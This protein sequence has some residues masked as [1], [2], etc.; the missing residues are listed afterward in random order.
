MLSIEERKKIRNLWNVVEES[1]KEIEKERIFKM[2][3]ILARKSDNR[4]TLEDFSQL[5]KLN[6]KT[7]CGLVKKHSHLFK[8]SVKPEKRNN[9][10][11]QDIKIR[12]T[13]DGL[14]I[15]RNKHLLIC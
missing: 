2:L 7:I 10:E 11:A 4:L 5:V 13:E 14:A 1:N 9:Y 3:D 12:I 15:L 6:L 8:V